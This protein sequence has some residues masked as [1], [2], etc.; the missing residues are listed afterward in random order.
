MNR[1]PVLSLSLHLKAID[2]PFLSTLTTVIFAF[3]P[4]SELILKILRNH[5]QKRGSVTHD[6]NLCSLMR[7][8]VLYLSSLSQ[9]TERGLRC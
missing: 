9:R 7:A 2:A 5:W 6:A 8:F 4:I 1:P 3:Y